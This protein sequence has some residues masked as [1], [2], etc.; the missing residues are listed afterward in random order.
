MKWVD[1]VG[2]SHGWRAIQYGPLDPRDSTMEITIGGLQSEGM[3]G[4]TVYDFRL[5][6]G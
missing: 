3:K 2:P 6:I 5:A 4:G 1:M